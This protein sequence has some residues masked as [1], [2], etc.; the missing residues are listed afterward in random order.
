[1]LPPWQADIIRALDGWRR[2]EDGRRRYTRSL[3]A[4]GRGNAK[5]SLVAGLSVKGL[6]GMG[7]L[8]PKVITAGTDRENAG[9]IFGYAAGMVRRDRRLRRRL[10]ILDSTKRILRDPADGAL[11]RVISADAGHAHGIHPT[12]LTIDD[13]QA[14]T[15]RA[16]L[17]VLGTSQSTV[18]EPLLVQCMTAGFDTASVGYEEWEHAERVLT[19]PALD[20]EL[21]VSLHALAPD[22]DWENPKTWR[23]ANPNLGVSVSEEYLRQ[24]VRRAI[25]RPSVRNDVLMLHFNI[26][27][28]GETVSWI[29]PEEWE[30]TAGE[31]DEERLRGRSCVAGVV[32]TSSQDIAC[33]LYLFPAEGE[34]PAAVIQDAF[35]PAAN[36]AR[37]EEEHRLSYAS[38]IADGS[39]SPT[40]GDVIDERAIVRQVERRQQ[41]GFQIQEVACNPRGT[42][43]LMRQLDEAGF[44]VTS[45]LPSYSAM[46][47]AMSELDK[48]VRAR[49][50]AHGGNRLLA[51]GMR[52]LRAR[53][54]PD[55]D[56]KPDA[57]R[58]SGNIA[59]PVALLMALSRVLAGVG[60]HEV[61]VT[62]A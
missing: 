30:A 18:A 53:R 46:S 14:Q 19:D 5:S 59:G 50:I 23:K 29:P 10:R 55:G 62:W 1:M 17:G 61:M 42:A 49:A 47:P 6:V 60:G 27:P 56:M 48:L 40:E 11:L 32:A 52:S 26:W 8:M 44:T 13:L 28:R 54:N 57:E 58:S 20:P 51:F 21:L 3:V 4:V 15:S 9:I 12:L 25:E 38:W 7:V 16:F 33:V 24:Q 43:A 2:E 34:L 45:V 22:D 41:E 37:L 35:V 31:V 39:L 36:I